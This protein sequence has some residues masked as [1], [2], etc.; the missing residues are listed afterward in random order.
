MKRLAPILGVVAVCAACSGC[1][2]NPSTWS[3]TGA[4]TSLD[5]GARDSG[6]GVPPDASTPGALDGSAAEPDSGQVPDDAGAPDTGA[7][8]L[9]DVGAADVGQP[10]VGDRDAGQPDTGQPDVGQ[11]DTGVLL[12]PTPFSVTPGGS[13]QDVRVS[14]E[15]N[16]FDSATATQLTGP[17]AQ[18]AWSGTVD[19]EPGTWAY[20]LT[21]DGNPLLDPAQGRRKYVAGVEYSALKVLDCSRPSLTVVASAAARP[22]SG[23]GAYQ[24]TLAY[25]DAVQGTG[26]DPT[27]FAAVLS[28]ASSE[29]AL[30]AAELT[31]DAAGGVA[32]AVSSLADGKYS[33]LVTPRSRGGA[34]GE[35]LRLVFW[36]EAEAFSW[37]DALIYSAM[38]DR[39]R[40]GD[41]SNNPAPTSGVDPR[42][43]FQGGDLEGVRRSLADGTLSA[44]GVRALWLTP[45]NTAPAGGELA[46][47][48]L[49]LITGYHGYWPVKAR[50]VEPRLGGPA[51][52]HSLVAE[53]HQQGIRVLLDFPMRQTHEAH[54]YFATSPGWYLADGCVCGSNNCDWTAHAYDC[55]LASYLPVIDHKNPAA[56]A[57]VVS[58]AIWWLDTFDLDGIRV[59]SVKQMPESATRNLAA[60]VREA[61]EAA[62]TR[63]FLT[64]ETAMGW[65]DC[66]DPC[67]DIN[68]G[69]ISQY[70]GPFGLDGQVDF[71]NYYATTIPTFAYGDKGFIHADY[72]FAHGLQ[73]WPAGAVM[74]P[75]LG[76]LDHPRFLTLADYRGQDAAH[77]RGIPGNQW[78]NIAAA[79]TDSE[80]YRR[81]RVALAW[82]LGLP[83]API[84]YYGD[85][86]GASGG[87][88]PNNRSF[89]RAENALTADETATL[90]LAR[91]LGKARQAIPAL[92]R[93]GYVSLLNTNE[94]VLVFG[95]R[96][97]AGQAAIVGLNRQATAATVG[98]DV[99]PLGLS[100]G[101][102]LSDALGGPDVTVGVGPMA[103]QIPANGAVVLH[104]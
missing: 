33:V 31:V 80:P 55:S 30:T 77:D 99:S 61:F 100:A 97:A 14:G 65:I 42:G 15:W 40:D 23:Q 43:D 56:N 21:V 10:D 13:P 88:D 86:Y 41:P 81:M 94:N 9:P 29:R 57:A 64:G 74:S 76:T 17:N 101:T 93:G 90:A 104:P 89:W 102:K 48:G 53:A 27:G 98:V 70:V 84:L 59:D 71:V 51:A 52:L 12:C 46:G 66:A 69:T 7:P 4:V 79:P 72:W 67:N 36:I 22:A 54:E 39:Y 8:D 1:E 16:A 62:G 2:N 37:Q 73:K 75:H 87:A 49:H 28:D 45:F 103:L 92:R 6:T 47:D 25:H 50:E 63:Y 11:P 18:G 3:D 19:L 44:L 68:Y 78:T 38:T 96:T 95:R 5:A 58:D 32:I 60:A 35:P 83:G 20:Q 82:L 85:E 24:A 91:K 26:A 34:T